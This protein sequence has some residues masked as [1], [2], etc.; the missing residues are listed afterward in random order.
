MMTETAEQA[1]VVTVQDVI[2]NRGKDV[3]ITYASDVVLAGGKKN[4]QQG[5]V[6][7]VTKD[8]L[9]TIIGKGDYEKARRDAGEAD[10][11]AQP[12][13]WGVRDEKTG[14]IEHKGEWYIEFIAKQKGETSYLLDNQPIKKDN[15][16]GLKP[17]SPAPTDDAVILRSVKLKNI[18]KLG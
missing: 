5:R 1:K 15:I 10:F 16:I 7:K 14:L 2:D 3:L 17:P 4:E 18:M 11:T 12:R 8:M 9:V 6:S 13:K